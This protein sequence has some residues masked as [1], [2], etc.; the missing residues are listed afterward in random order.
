M[1]KNFYLLVGFTILTILMWLFNLPTLLVWLFTFAASLGWLIK[2]ADWFTDAA[3]DI[4][5]AIHISPFVI[6]VTIVSVGTSLP[7]LSTS[8]IA[9]WQGDTTI[10]IANA[11]GSN[12]ANILLVGGISAIVA[13]TLKVTRN[14]ID[15]DLPLLLGITILMGIMLMDGEFVWQEGVMAITFFIIYSIYTIKSSEKQDKV[16]FINRFHLERK[17]TK[18]KAP[19]PA[20]GLAGLGAVGVYFGADWTIKSIFAVSELLN[21]NSSAIAMS[22]LAIGTSLPELVVSATAAMRGRHEVALG[23][24][25]GSNIFNL[26]MVIGVPSLFSTLYVDQNSLLIGL[27][28]LMG[29]T[30]LYVF[31]G[32]SQKIHKW[33]GF[34]YLFIYIIFMVKLF[35]IF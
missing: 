20:I 12:I 16:P 28:I 7:E 24:I 22:A 25:F 29:V 17:M 23:N 34:V 9:L 35:N 13:G 6:G 26:L 18:F 15:I 30:I 21:I 27:P 5:E 19:W 8:I 2:S 14:L 1:E 4:G 3:E 11:I 31:S 33:E 32:I 10:A